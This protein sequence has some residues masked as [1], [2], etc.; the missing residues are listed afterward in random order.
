MVEH[1]GPQLVV[2]TPD[3]IERI[4]S[5]AEQTRKGWILEAAQSFDI[6]DDWLNGIVPDEVMVGRV[7]KKPAVGSVGR[8]RRG[9]RERLSQ[10]W[11]MDGEVAH[12]I[13]SD[14][15]VLI[16]EVWDEGGDVG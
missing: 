5:V 13:A 11:T 8:A 3:F 4:G 14:L 10:S 6:Y 16:R 12:L 15:D 9:G 7:G 1:V 2:A